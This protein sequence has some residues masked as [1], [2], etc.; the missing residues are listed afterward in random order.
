MGLHYPLRNVSLPVRECLMSS[1][2][3]QLMIVDDVALGFF[4]GQNPP[5]RIK[6][7]G[8]F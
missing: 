3:R 8:D 6:I 4:R 5:F 1:A 7:G 2:V